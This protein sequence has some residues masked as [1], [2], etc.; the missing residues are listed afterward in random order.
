ME[1]VS[2]HSTKGIKKRQSKKEIKN[3]SLIDYIADYR[4]L[5]D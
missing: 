1:C 3:V 5:I 2:P 4:L